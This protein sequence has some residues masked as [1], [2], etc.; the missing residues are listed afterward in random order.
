LASGSFDKTVAVYAY[1]PLPSYPNQEQYEDLLNYFKN[2][3]VLAQEIAQR[4][5]DFIWQH[6]RMKDVKCYWRNLLKRYEKLMKYE[7]QPDP[8][9]THIGGPKDEL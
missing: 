7:V 2:N 4:G 1:V 8:E 5:H 3:D 9:M 6:L